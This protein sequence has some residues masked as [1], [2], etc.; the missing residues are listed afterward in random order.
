[1][2]EVTVS[3]RKHLEYTK[4]FWLQGETN[5][6]K[7]KSFESKKSNVYIAIHSLNLHMQAALFRTQSLEKEFESESNLKDGSA[8]L[9]LD[10]LDNF[11]SYECVREQL[12]AL[13]IELESCQGCL[14]ETEARVDKKYCVYGNDS[15]PEF[16]HNGSDGRVE[17]SSVPHI[18]K[19]PPIVLYDIEEPVIEDEVF[20]AYVDEEYC[21]RQKDD[22]SDEFWNADIRKER[23]MMK[24]QKE[25]GKRVLKELHP[26]L[27]QRRKMW[28]GREE[29]ALS[30]QLARKNQVRYFFQTTVIFF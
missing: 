22:F 12:N 4:S 21:D 16:E 30:K 7:P 5:E 26:I 14:E 2:Q 23:Q 28:E 8:D 20:E 3:L 15:V 24:Q 19:K 13:K 9:E 11:P 10:N 25:Q 6:V 17:V 27:V 1:M 18:G 29:V